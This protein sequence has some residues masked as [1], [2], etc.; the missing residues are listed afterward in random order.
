M[1]YLYKNTISD[2]KYLKYLRQKYHDFSMTHLYQDEMGRGTFPVLTDNDFLSLNKKVTGN[3]M[4]LSFF[5]E[6]MSM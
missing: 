5:L 3:T 6:A 1:H 4:N 2:L